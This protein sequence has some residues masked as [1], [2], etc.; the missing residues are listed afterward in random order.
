MKFDIIEY[1]KKIKSQYKIT[2][3]SA[4]LFGVICHGMGIFNKYSYS[5]DIAV[6]FYSFGSTIPSG[7]W[8]LELFSKIELFIFGDGHYSLPVI[9]GFMSFIYIG[10]AACLIVSLLEIKNKTLCICVGTLMVSF[11]S[12]TGMFGY[13]FTVPSYTL[14]MLLGVYGTYLVCKNSSYI[15][16]SIGII[17]MGCSVGV[18]QAFIPVMLSFFVIYL[19]KECLYTE[20][21]TKELINKILK[22]IL[23]IICFI[24]LYFITN[25]LVLSFSGRELTTYQGINTMGK[26]SISDYLYRVVYAYGRF[27]IIDE[28]QKYYM[29]YSNIK[30]IYY[31]L[32]AVSFIYLGYIAIT[33]FKQ[34]KI[35]SI[36]LVLLVAAMPLASNFIFV[37]VDPSQVHALMVYGQIMPFILVMLLIDNV[38]DKKDI[39]KKVS[40]VVTTALLLLSV[41]YCRID[42]ECYLQAEFS[43]QETISYFTT[44]VTRIKSVENYDDELPVSFIFIDGGHIEDKSFSSIETLEHLHIIPYENMYYTINNYEWKTF[45]KRW[46]GYDPVIIDGSDLES[47]EEVKAMSCY[48]DYGSIKVIEDRVVVRFR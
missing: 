44:L 38:I 15:K 41:M 13:M 43:Q 37:M 9:N 26:D 40:L 42:N 19:I 23:S 25:K 1:F 28:K 3:I 7:R 39:I 21:E 29:Y 16:I 31:F 11:P 47:N 20:I 18:Y 4:I 46:C 22:S 30:Y 33:K 48:P 6:G 45:M 32:M 17:L 5:D 2:F 8:M 10:I 35:N 36:I 12:V 14:G 24:L 27:F 34:S